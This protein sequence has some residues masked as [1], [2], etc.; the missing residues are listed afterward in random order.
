M[1]L[2]RKNRYLSQCFATVDPRVHDGIVCS[3]LNTIRYGWWQWKY[4][5]KRTY[6][7]TFSSL[8]GTWSRH[9]HWAFQF[10]TS[11][12]N[13]FWNSGQDL[14]NTL[15]D[16]AFPCPLLFKLCQQDLENVWVSTPWNR[17]LLKIIF[18]TEGKQSKNRVANFTFFELEFWLGQYINQSCSVYL[19][20]LPSH[21]TDI[22]T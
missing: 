7:Y 20:E 10:N 4:S 9:E 19:C 3:L 2:E 8:H 18:L 22:V 12:S 14:S 21:R 15:A 5:Q 13:L 17:T 1:F 6:S 11:F 16:M